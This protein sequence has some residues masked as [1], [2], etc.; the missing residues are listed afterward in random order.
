MN[1]R[2]SVLVAEDNENDVL[3]LRHV[4]SKISTDVFLA[5]VNDGEEAIKYLRGENG[6][7]DRSK[8][9]FPDVL[10]LDLKMPRLDGFDVLAWLRNHPPLHR[11][12]VIVFTSSG[13]NLDVERA[14]DLGASSYFRKP[15]AL[16]DMKSIVDCLRGWLQ[17][18]QFAII[19]DAQYL[20]RESES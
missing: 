1:M 13:H 4:F 3:I 9:P 14:Y 12:R 6:F 11:L 18:N 7:S 5:F 19:D 2:W 20:K 15:T 16:N 8:H 10:L 17:L